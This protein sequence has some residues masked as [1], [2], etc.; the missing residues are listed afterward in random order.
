MRWLTQ[1]PVDASFFCAILAIIYK[2]ARRNLRRFWFSG[3][4]TTGRPRAIEGPARAV[5]SRGW[6]RTLATP[7]IRPGINQRNASHGA[8]YLTPDREPLIAEYCHVIH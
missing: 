1:Y 3:D 7:G 6:L 8:R 4:S 2:S 5:C